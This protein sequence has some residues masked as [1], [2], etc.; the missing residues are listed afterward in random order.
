[1]IGRARRVPEAAPSNA[2]REVILDNGSRARNVC[3]ARYSTEDDESD[4]GRHKWRKEAFAELSRIPLVR[5]GLALVRAQVGAAS[6][7]SAV[8]QASGALV[9]SRGTLLLSLRRA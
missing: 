6:D 7:Q 5:P 3:V 1:M 4:G 8:G 9:S 2:L